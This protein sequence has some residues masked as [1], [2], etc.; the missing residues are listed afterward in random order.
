VEYIVDP[1]EPAITEKVVTPWDM[2]KIS[3]WLAIIGIALIT[4]AAVWEVSPNKTKTV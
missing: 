2:V 4:V 3:D 1:V